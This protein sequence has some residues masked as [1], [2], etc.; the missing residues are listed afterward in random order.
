MTTHASP[1]SPTTLFK[2][3]MA[4]LK[5]IEPNLF[6]KKTHNASNKTQT[7]YK[8]LQQLVDRKYNT[9][10]IDFILSASIRIGLLSQINGNIAHM[11]STK[12]NKICEY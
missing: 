5:R 4:K 10:C 12:F 11:S 8:I 7:F 9:I 6:E 2:S 3:N 1:N